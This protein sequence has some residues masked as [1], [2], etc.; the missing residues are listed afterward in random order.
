M[1]ENTVDCV[2]KAWK[3]L[4]SSVISSAS[5]LTFRSEAEV[6][7]GVDEAVYTLTLVAQ[8]KRAIVIVT[9]STR[10][11]RKFPEE[12]DGQNGKESNQLPSKL[13]NS[14]SR[15]PPDVNYT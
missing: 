7:V 10:S 12:Q 2:V 13:W 8:T 6:A 3:K 5:R 11:R 9:G 14:I 4:I 1:F 15:E